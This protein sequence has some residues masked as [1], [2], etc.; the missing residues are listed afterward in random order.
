MPSEAEGVD[1][2]EGSGSIQEPVAAAEPEDPEGD[3]LDQVVTETEEEGAEAE[4]EEAPEA[5]DP[6]APSEEPEPEPAENAEHVA[7]RAE[8]EALRARDQEQTGLLREL[9]SRL[10]P[11][12][13]EQQPEVD[14]EAVEALLSGEADRA[15]SIDPGKAAKARV[16]LQA[17]RDRLHQEIADPARHRQTVAEEAAKLA[18]VM[19]VREFAPLFREAL[20]ARERR[21]VE[22]ELGDQK[23]EADAVLRIA[24]DLAKEL[25]L[26]APNDAVLRVAATKHKA[27][28]VLRLA[29]KANGAAKAGKARERAEKTAKAEVR[30]GVPPAQRPTFGR[31]ATGGGLRDQLLAAYERDLKR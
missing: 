29:G 2:E 7:L 16:A 31:P 8:V 9:A 19:V 1:D 27:D 22:A 15:K 23:G 20:A 30:T 5:P 4:A 28:T 10:L 17:Y 18:K 14:R 12:R 3:W 21:L 26:Q 11:P 13:V 24:A 25:G 6:E